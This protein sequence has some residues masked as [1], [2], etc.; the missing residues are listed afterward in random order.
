MEYVLTV[1]KVHKMKCDNCGKR[2][3]NLLR[4]KNDIDEDVYICESCYNSSCEGYILLE[5]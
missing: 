4:A 3:L 1:K 2:V 5:N